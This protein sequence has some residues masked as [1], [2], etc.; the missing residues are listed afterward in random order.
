MHYQ[1]TF[2][3]L[4]SNTSA[5]TFALEYKKV[6][7]AYRMDK[8]VMECQIYPLLRALVPVIGKLVIS[9]VSCVRIRKVKNLSTKGN[10]LLNDWFSYAVCF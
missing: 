8:R 3:V 6:N 1:K 4:F 5:L 2:R 9:F 10:L 7:V